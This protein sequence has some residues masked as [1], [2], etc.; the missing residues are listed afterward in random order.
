METGAGG[1]VFL[2]I[3]GITQDVQKPDGCSGIRGHHRPGAEGFIPK[4]SRNRSLKAKM[5][6]SNFPASIGSGNLKYFPLKLNDLPSL[7][8]CKLK[9]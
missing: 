3:E 5:L 7:M 8:G 6:T 9:I 2:R 1:I 4:I